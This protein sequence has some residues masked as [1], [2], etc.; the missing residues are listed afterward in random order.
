[1]KKRRIC[2]ILGAAVMIAAMSSTM[3]HAE[4]EPVTIS[5]A[6][7]ETD[8]YTADYYQHIIDT[9]EA[10]NPNIKIEKVLM[11]GDSRPQFLKTMLSAG[12]M[13]DVNIDP[14]D[15]ADIEGVYAEV[16]EELLSKYEDGYIVT[17]NGSKNLIP[18]YTALRSQVYYNKQ[19]FEEAGITEV[20]KTWDEFTAACD[21]LTEAGF[22]PLMGV[23]AADSWATSFGYWSGVVNAE[24]EAAYP[25][26][27]KQVL[28]GE[29][30]WTD[31]VIEE[32]LVKWQDLINAGYYHKG[33]MSF[34][35]PQASAEFLSGSAAMF[36][37]GA[38]AC[39]TIDSDEAYKDKFGVFVMPT[40]SGASSYC[41]MPG[42]WAV[43]ETCEN[44]E[45]AFTF[46]EY[47]LGGNK[48]LY[49]YYLQADGVYSVTKEPVTYEMGTLQTE[50]LENYDNMEVVPE[51]TK[52]VG[53]Y[54]LPSGF[55]DYTWKS[56]Q[57]VF[58]GADV[59]TELEAWDAEFARMLEG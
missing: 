42:Y 58:T 24:V 53:D 1:M 41:T 7:F 15:L 18:A 48:D 31:S 16:P 21:K 26:F 37:D 23:G 14:V 5:W 32:T 35:H 6:V 46:C 12:N 28:A 45:A 49:S 38:W 56:L 40:P 39:A 59:K 47:V 29:V 10:D 50:F 17:N 33:S 52:L 54:K 36:M 3:V 44:K 51:I 25:E 20:P 9:F 55:E 57:N 34:S 19:Q 8:N 43:S 11:T 27:N 22:T 13:P 4:S 30:S 2:T